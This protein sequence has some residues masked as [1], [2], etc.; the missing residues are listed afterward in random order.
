MKIKNWM[1]GLFSPRNKVLSVYRRG[2]DK[3][4]K[5]DPQGA[6]EDYSQVIEMLQAPRDVVSMALFNRGL[7]YT[8]N[9]EMD[10]GMR[11]LTAV[12]AM[13]A[14]PEKVKSMARQKLLRMRNRGDQQDPG[15]LVEED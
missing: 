12:L 1:E 8:A 6:I 5:H 13:P 14:A 7:V 10:K 15:R 4:K 2:L 11:D 9:G 3:A